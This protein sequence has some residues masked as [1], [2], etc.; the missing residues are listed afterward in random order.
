M[1]EGTTGDCSLSNF[2]VAEYRYALQEKYSCEECGLLVPACASTPVGKSVDPLRLC[3][4]PLR[5]PVPSHNRHRR[6][7]EHYSL[8]PPPITQCPHQGDA[9]AS[10]AR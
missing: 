5:S 1:S 4:R 3:E 7:Y 2:A 8:Q 6:Q 9:I 10:P